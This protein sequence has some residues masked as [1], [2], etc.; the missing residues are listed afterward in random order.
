MRRPRINNQIR[1]SEVRVID[2]DE[3]QVGVI[4]L[5]EALQLAK[6][7]GL[8]LVQV[9]EKVSPPVCKITDYGKY[10][11][12][13]QKKEKNKKQKVSQLKGIRLSFKISD[14]D[15][16]IRVKQAEKFL[17][18][19]NKVKIDLILRGREKALGDYA[20]KKIQ[21]FLDMLGE[22]ISIKTER[23]LKRGPRGFTMIISR[24]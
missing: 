7:R 12:S 20:K 3:K 4:P 9:T 13:L 2:I 23:Q 21:K 24:G 22:S 1:V 15:M 19:G 8:D 16:K 6:E 11:Y 14:H 18:G 17:K 10:L 5:Q